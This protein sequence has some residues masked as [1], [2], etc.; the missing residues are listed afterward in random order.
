MK[1]SYRNA[2]LCFGWL[3]LL[4]LCVSFPEGHT[5]LQTQGIT[6][7]LYLAAAVA[8]WLVVYVCNA[9]AFQEIINLSTPTTQPLQSSS[10][11]SFF[12]ALQLTIS[13][14]AFSYITPF[15][16][17]GTPYRVLELSPHIGTT[18]AL[19]AVTLYAMTHVFSH[20]FLWTTAIV[21]FVLFYFQQL[22][23]VLCLGLGIY[24]LFFVV[25]LWVFVRGYRRGF[26]LFFLQKCAQIPWFKSRIAPFCVRY[27]DQAVQ[28]DHHLALL[29]RHRKLFYRVLGYEYLA[30]LLN[31]FEFYFMFLVIGI[32]EASFVDALLVLAFAS[33]M[34]NILFF[35]PMQLGAREGG[36]ILILKMLWGYTHVWGM[37]LALFT[38][39]REIFWVALGLVLLR[40]ARKR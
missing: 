39:I 7:W 6:F 13:G 35:L 4:L 25:V 1:N 19:S 17:G 26:C 21:L 18:R 3:A 32:Q 34:G 38:R 36:I 37:Y 22:N 23:F 27:Y 33:F 29:Y 12:Q 11:C 31:S 16:S 14:F 40:W 9:R 2:F 10:S 20:F 15:G 28:I 5:M 24:L 8:S 30:R